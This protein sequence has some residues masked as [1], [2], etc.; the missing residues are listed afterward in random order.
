[1]RAGSRGSRRIRCPVSAKIALAT[2]GVAGPAVADG[3][4]G[5][6]VYD[7]FAIAKGLGD[8]RYDPSGQVTRLQMAAGTTR[9]KCATIAEVKNT[10]TPA[11]LE[12]NHVSWRVCA[13][14]TRAMPC[15]RWRPGSTW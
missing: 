3:P 1:M 13:S 8:G 9:F 15:C 12:T 11:A 6:R 4:G 10:A 14:W 5:F 7:I 2:A